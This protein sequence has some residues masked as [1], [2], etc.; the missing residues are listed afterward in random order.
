[1]AYCP[2][3]LGLAG[4]STAREIAN[5]QGFEQTGGLATFGYQSTRS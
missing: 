4:G 2:M 3:P 1:M 5:R